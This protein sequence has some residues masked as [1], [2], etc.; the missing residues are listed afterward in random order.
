MSL[1]EPLD[2]VGSVCYP[3]F[4]KLVTNWEIFEA[5][6]SNYVSFRLTAISTSQVL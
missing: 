3:L 1:S 4:Q 5:V 6:L 2:H